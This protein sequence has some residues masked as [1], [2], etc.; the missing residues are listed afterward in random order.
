MLTWLSLS[1]G[2]MDKQTG[3]GKAPGGVLKAAGKQDIPVIAIGGY[4][5]EV[6]ELNAMGFLAVLPI[7]PFPATLE[8]AM[9]K[10][11]TS[12]NITRTLEQQLR[13]IHYFNSQNI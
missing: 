10:E 2:K 7:L 8:Q 3:M 12:N 1:E 4:V 9:Q 6:S 11:F 13:V 5:E